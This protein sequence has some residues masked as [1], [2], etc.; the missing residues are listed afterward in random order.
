LFVLKCTHTERERECWLQSCVSSYLHRSN[1][2]AR[3]CAWVVPT[4]GTSRWH[5]QS[6]RL[7][8]KCTVC[9]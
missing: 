7:R 2:C 8:R 6:Q 5:L 9:I 3:V 4:G 1:A